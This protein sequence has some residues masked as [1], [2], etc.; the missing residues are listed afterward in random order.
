MTDSSPNGPAVAGAHLVVI[1]AG[2]NIGSH[3]VPLLA[4][5]QGVGRLTLI[6]RDRYEA[7]NLVSQDAG[8]RDVGHTKVSVQ[9]RRAR[10]ANSALRVDAVH[11]PVEQLPLGALRGDLILTCLDSRAARQYVN[12]ASRRLG[13]PWI[14][15]GVMADLWLARVSVYS[16]AADTAC[17][18]CA[19]SQSDYASLE[20]TFACGATN[21]V[22][23]TGA[24]ASLGA[25]A[26][27]MQAIEC[28]RL[29]TLVSDATRI[30]CREIITA[31]LHGRQWGTALRRQATCRLPDH[32][33]WHIAS[34]PF[35]SLALTLAQIAS[36]E[37]AGGSPHLLKV[38]VAG[39]RFA[40][41]VRCVEC[42]EELPRARA[43]QDGGET[44]RPRCRRCGHAMHATAVDRVDALAIDALPRWLLARPL[45]RLGV[46]ALDVM[47]LSTRDG[48]R[49]LAI[50]PEPRSR[51]MGRST[52]AN[53]DRRQP[54]EARRERRTS[55]DAGHS[56][57]PSRRN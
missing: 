2:G 11:A 35:G 18:E 48:E 57:I 8:A 14:D 51:E 42:G 32:K 27:A 36:R 56:P 55:G 22:A 50:G 52:E 54:P 17:M 47:T 19:W 7:A 43:I 12:E 30:E 23:A 44:S 31:A 28:Q 25:L 3:L 1:G 6:D 15:A 46:R 16:N 40:L 41:R 33:P 45:R 38:S 13:I 20:Q 10:C 29:L 39:R 24:A 53:P 21:A 9:A 26:A 49:H 5:T 4:R 34:L 37:G